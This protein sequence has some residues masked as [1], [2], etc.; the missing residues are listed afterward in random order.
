MAITHLSAADAITSSGS[1]L[2]L[3]PAAV[4]TTGAT[5]IVL[6]TT[7]LSG[8][9]TPT[10]TDSKGNSWT[11]LTPQASTGAITERVFY[12]FPPS[13]KT[14]TGHTFTATWGSLP[15][16]VVTVCAF[17]GVKNTAPTQ[18]GANWGVDDGSHNTLQPGAIMPPVA[19]CLFVS[20]YAGNGTGADVPSADSGFTTNAVNT[21]GNTTFPGGSAWLID[22]DTTTENPTWSTNHA[23]TAFGMCATMAC[24]QPSPTAASGGAALRK[25]FWDGQRKDPG[26]RR[27][28]KNVALGI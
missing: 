14:G 20:G 4:D 22:S 15:Y 23:A 28:L 10:I 7:G 25:W 27:K 19:G 6:S 1:L 11:A 16:A 3:T 5:L 12:C 18:S 26:P 2:A 13:N 24:F 8:A 21:G 17:S 9:G